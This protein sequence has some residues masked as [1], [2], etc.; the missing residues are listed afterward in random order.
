MRRHERG[1]DRLVEDRQVLGL[2]GGVVAVGVVEVDRR[3]VVLVL[4]TEQRR[5]VRAGVVGQRR[6][7]RAVIV[8]ALDAG[9]GAVD[10]LWSDTTLV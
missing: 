10:V 2:I 5:V 3:V 6:R 9:V 8:V 4:G 1:T 7:L